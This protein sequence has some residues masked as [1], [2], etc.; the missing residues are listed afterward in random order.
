LAHL[1]SIADAHI[2]ETVNSQAS[3]AF[4]IILEKR[5]KDRAR[6]RQVQVPQFHETQLVFMRD[7]APGVSTIL[8]I[9]NKGPYRIDK[10][11]DR[12]VTLTEIGT[13]K[14]VHSHIQNIRPLEISEFRLLLSKGWDLNAHQLKTGLPISKPGIFDFAEHPVPTETVIETERRQDRLPEEGDLENLFQ[15]PQQI[16]LEDTVQ[17]PPVQPEIPPAVPAEQP[18]AVPPDIPEERPPVT[19]RRSPRMNP[20]TQRL[21]AMNTD[22]SETYEI[23]DDECDLGEQTLSVNTADV[24][25]EISSVYRATLGNGKVQRAYPLK[26]QAMPMRPILKREKSISFCLPDDA[27]HIYDD[28]L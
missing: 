5:K 13:G 16:P 12:N 4:R 21:D 7:Q 8:K 19:L 22:L 1:S 11:A 9:P 15:N 18:L 17:Y 3:D 10:L 24:Q 6:K 28:V 25:L 27:P 20:S 2:N 26:V 14:T 23:S